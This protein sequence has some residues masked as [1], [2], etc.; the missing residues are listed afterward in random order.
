MFFLTIMHSFSL[1]EKHLAAHVFL[2]P[3]GAEKEDPALGTG[4]LPRA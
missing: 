1:V 4:N 3:Y 2:W